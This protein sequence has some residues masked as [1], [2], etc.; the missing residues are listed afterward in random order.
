MRSFPEL[1]FLL[2]PSSLRSAR[3]YWGRPSP[4]RLF[5]LDPT[6]LRHPTVDTSTPQGHNPR[7]TRLRA[8]DALRPM[9]IRTG[10]LERSP[11]GI[12]YSAGTTK[13]LCTTSL[14][15]VVPPFLEGKGRGWA[16]AEYELLPGATTPR[17]PR[18]RSGKISGRTQEIQRLIG[19]AIRGAIDFA[20]LSGFT[21]QVDCDVLEADGGT[22]TAA[23]NG[24]WV[25][26]CILLRDAVE[27]GILPRSPIREA[28]AAVSVGKVGGE[29]L[30][31]L[32][33]E[34]DSSADVD[35]NVV[36]TEG[37][38]YLEVQGAAENGAFD[39]K[40]LDRMLDLAQV[41]IRR[42]IEEQRRVVGKP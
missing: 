19:R 27:R 23:I 9:S 8:I 17:H 5:G 4:G 13:V 42:I 14:S 12:L 21:L 30:L 20:A 28:V 2:A 36:M 22:R 16:T 38:R 25:S 18:E 24:A 40:D 10:F 6:N 7:M 32:D 11:A 33:Y 3:F 41:G 31:D 37:G 26:A 35:L 29:L 1:R 15:P 34:E 39:R